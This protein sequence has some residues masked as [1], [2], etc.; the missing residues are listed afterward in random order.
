[1]KRF[2]FGS[3]QE[4]EGSALESTYPFRID[5]VNLYEYLWTWI[6]MIEAWSSWLKSS[7]STRIKNSM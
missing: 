3:R 4:A 7:Q 1:M 2:I 5:T 6:F